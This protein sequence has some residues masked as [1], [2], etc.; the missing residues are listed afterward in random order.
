[1]LILQTGDDT[2]VEVEDVDAAEGGFH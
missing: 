1:V 2:V